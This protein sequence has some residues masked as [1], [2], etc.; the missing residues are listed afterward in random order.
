VNK[1]YEQVQELFRDVK[2][3]WAKLDNNR[4]LFPQICFDALDRNFDF[5]LDSVEEI[6]NL[7][8][9]K[10]SFPKDQFGELPITIFSNNDFFIDMYL[11]NL[12]HTSIHDHSFE[13]AFKLL[14]GK[15][16]QTIYEFDVKE[17]ISDVIKKGVLKKVS[18]HYN[19]P[20]KR[21]QIHK[22]EN[23]IHEVIH[24]KAPTVTLLVRNYWY[25]RTLAEY[26]QNFSFAPLSNNNDL[27]V[28]IRALSYFYNFQKPNRKAVLRTI[29]SDF[30]IQELASFIRLKKIISKHCSSSEIY[31][32]FN[33]DLSDALLNSNDI[34]NWAHELFIDYEAQ[35]RRIKRINNLKLI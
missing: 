19:E 3:E 10:Q 32:D 16:H 13:G 23:F 27:M 21:Q 7:Q 17:E 14:S 8:L 6:I 30:N 25:E 1:L 29:C 33:K 24:L 12:E 26:T 34:P 5:S 15:S 18:T 9:P 20:G 28:K 22:Y 35:S 31:D 11:W 2:N 4:D